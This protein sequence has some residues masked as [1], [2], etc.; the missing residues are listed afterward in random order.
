MPP[1]DWPLRVHDIL[2]QIALVKAHTAGA[3]QARFALDSLLQGDAM[4]RIGIIGEAVA[5]IPDEV[6]ASHPEVPW[7]VIRN[8]RNVLTH[9]YFQVDIDRVW[10]VIETD[11]DVLRVQMEALLI[12]EGHALP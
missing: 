1:R 10:Q 5:G 9:V 8:M 12:A 7:R 3:D 11:L 4:Y 6:K 2:D